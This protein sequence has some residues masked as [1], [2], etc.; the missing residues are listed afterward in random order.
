MG[1]KMNVLLLGN[2][3]DLHHD[4]PTTYNNF[5][6]TVNFL[7]DNYDETKMTSIGKVFND[8]RLS[9]MDDGIKHSYAKYYTIYSI[10]PLD[11]AYIKQLI[12]YAKS[13]AWFTYLSKI[14]EKIDTWIDFEKE[15]G[16]VINA[17]EHF[18]KKNIRKELNFDGFDY[19][20]QSIIS[21]FSFFYSVVE[22]GMC[23]NGRTKRPEVKDEYL[24]YY[25]LS[26]SPFINKK[27]IIDK[28]Y[29]QLVELSEMLKLYLKCF[30]ENVL[31][32]IAMSDLADIRNIFLNASHIFT[33]NYTNTFEKLYHTNDKKEVYHIHGNV[34]DNIVL[35]LNSNTCD[36]LDELN[37][38]FICFKKYYQRVYYKTDM[39]YLSAIK[40]TGVF[41]KRIETKLSVI[42]H[43]LDITDQ[44]IIMTLFEYA[45]EITVYCH[46]ES[47][48]GDYIRNLISIYGKR[49]FDKLRLDKDLT[50]KLLND[51]IQ[52][53]K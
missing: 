51:E 27:K 48:I 18:F 16:H 49:E 25:T 31:D 28:I 10:F 29:K 20:E 8:E 24:T 19:S 21:I 22:D 4:L 13:N 33:L 44:E 46:N 47:A 1:N 9:G 30:V 38:D 50:F 43:S 5:I 52:A 11:A 32:K 39:K 40:Y 2:G 12:D 3:F 14:S 34:C 6:N 36:E 7:K 45:T 42:G 15:I 37:T 23:I 41:D 26:Q 35:G 17:F 53:D